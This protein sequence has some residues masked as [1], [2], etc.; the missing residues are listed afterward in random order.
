LGKNAAAWSHV[1]EEDELDSGL[2]WPLG[3]EVGRTK[4][5][6]RL[7]AGPQ[8]RG[9]WASAGLPVKNREGEK[10]LSRLGSYQGSGP[11]ANRKMRKGFLFFKSFLN[12]KP[13]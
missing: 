5:K 2:S 13:I 4:R 6:R 7:P 9:S 1:H 11:M 8:G 3:R 12:F 10:G